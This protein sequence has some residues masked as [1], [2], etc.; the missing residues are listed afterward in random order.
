MHHFNTIEKERKKEK[1]EEKERIPL[2]HGGRDS[3]SF[4]KIVLLIE[5]LNNNTLIKRKR[6]IKKNNIPIVS[7]IN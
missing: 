2:L 7:D 1:E 3:K 5:Y 6:I 4:L